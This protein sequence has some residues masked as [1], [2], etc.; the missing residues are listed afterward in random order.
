VSGDDLI[1]FQEETNMKRHPNIL[2]LMSD[3][4]NANCLGIAGHPDVKTPHLDRIARGGIRFTRGY[5]NNP[6]C[7]PSRS[8]FLSGQ[9]VRTHG[10][11]GNF[12]REARCEAPNLA[13]L[14][15][16]NGY[17]TAF[18][19]K[20]HLPS[21]WVRDGFEY[22]RFSDLCDAESNNPASCHYFSDLIKAGLADQYDQGFCPPGHPGYGNRA[23]VSELPEEFSLEAWTGREAVRF[24]QQRNSGQPFFLQ[25]SFQRPHDPFSPPANRADDYDAAALSLPDN[26]C[27]YLSRD[28]AG[29]PIFQQEYIRGEKGLGYPF[30]AHDSTELKRQM[31]AHF[32]L[33]TMVDEA[34]G[35]VLK[36]IEAQGELDNTIIAYVADHGDFAGEHGLTQKNLGI[37]E[38]IHRIPF[39]LAGPGV[40][41]GLIRDTLIESVDFYPTLAALA[42]LKCE[43]EVDGTSRVQ[44]MKTG[45]GRLSF[46]VCEWDFAGPQTRVHA[47]RDERY[48]F[49]YYDEAPEDGE[50][51]DHQNDPGELNNLFRSATHQGVCALFITRLESYRAGARRVH[52]WLED[53]RDMTATQKGPTALI[54]RFGEKW[55]GICP[56]FFDKSCV[57]LKEEITA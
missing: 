15:R 1:V 10:I 52:G 7:A 35:D 30:L 41:V 39:I 49:V 45:E 20:A 12:V 54:H 13:R 6:I 31:A 38:S 2:W 55:S 46:A 3:Q 56:L 24:L 9:Y 48:R 5:C 27:D 50:L 14:F 28:F 16:G 8:S 43:P 23:F 44:E 17:E 32:T 22:I 40:P 33:I 21:Q 53:T 51:Y 26:A 29:K 37:Y 57:R 19:G 18:V 47:L 25:V 36:E 34:I 4:H 42:G 11:S